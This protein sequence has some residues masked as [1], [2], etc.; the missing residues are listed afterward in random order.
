MSKVIFLDFDGP[1]IPVR[2]YWLPNQTKPI[3]STFDPVAVSLVNKLIEDSGAK[4]VISSSWR[5]QGFEE[6]MATLEK[7]GID[8]KHVHEDWDTPAKFSSQRIHEIKWWL[9]DH[10]EVTHYVA[11][12]DENLHVEFVPNAVLADA[13]EGFSMR[14]YLEARLMLD[15]YSADQQDRK[16]E[17]EELI[18]YLKKKEVWR[19]KRS[20][21][22]DEWKTRE[23]VTVLLENDKDDE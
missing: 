14:N 21:E 18:G 22:I 3:V 6:V 1:M 4:L 13:Y 15:A 10:P 11:I 7:N 2:A 16:A 8:P 9:G 12:D 23:M 20:G 5:M 17:H 19:L